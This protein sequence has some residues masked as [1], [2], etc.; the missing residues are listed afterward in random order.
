MTSNLPV[1]V[2]VFVARLGMFGTDAVVG[3][4]LKRSRTSE[5]EVALRAL[6]RRA[7]FM[8]NRHHVDDAFWNTGAF[9]ANASVFLATGALPLVVQADTA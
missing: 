5:H 3:C 2:A 6:L 7:P 4:M 1:G 8:D 9:V